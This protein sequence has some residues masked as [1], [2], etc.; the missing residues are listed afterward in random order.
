MNKIALLVVDIQE[1]L[2]VKNP[3]NKEITINNIELLIKE[4]RTNNVEVIYVRHDGGE[5]DELESGSKGW[6][7]YD[8][9]APK[10]SEKI[11]EKQY[12][13]SFKNTE[14]KEYLDSKNIDTLI[15]V[16]MQ[17]EYCIDTTCKVAF[18][19]GFKLI[20]PEETNTTFDNGCISGKDIYKYYNFK[21]WKNRFARL[22][23]VQDVIKL[24]T[25]SI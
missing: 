6:Q 24:F 13:S 15:L 18:E 5:G 25:R 20:I 7:I 3:F 22:E 11:I 1:G 14:L 16:G 19:Y 23:K 12:N 21:I 10:N 17:T 4:C 2:V 9:I 8:K